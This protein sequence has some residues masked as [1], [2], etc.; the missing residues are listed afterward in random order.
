MSDKRPRHTLYPCTRNC[1]SICPRVI[2]CL[3]ASTRKGRKLNCAWR[4]SG[5]RLVSE[6]VLVG[7]L[8]TVSRKAEYGAIEKPSVMI[9]ATIRRIQMNRNGIRAIFVC[10]LLLGLVGCSPPS[11]SFKFTSDEVVVPN[12]EAPTQIIVTVGNTDLFVGHGLFPNLDE[13]IRQQIT[14]DIQSKVFPRLVSY[15]ADL[16][17][18]VNLRSLEHDRNVWALVPYCILVCLPVLLG[19]PVGYYHAETAILVEI[20]DGSGNPIAQYDVNKKMSGW[21]NLYTVGDYDSP[22]GKKWFP[23]LVVA[24]AMDDLKARIRADRAK[25]VQAADDYRKS[26]D[27]KSTV[28][29]SSVDVFPKVSTL[30]SPKARLR[31]A[32]AP[33]S[34]L[35]DIS[36]TQQG[37]IF[38]T[39]IGQVAEFYDLVSQEEYQRAEEQAFQSTDSGQCTEERCIRAIQEFLQIENIFFLQMIRDAEDTQLSVTL[40]TLDKRIPKSEYCEACGTRELNER[41]EQLLD[42]VINRR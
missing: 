38:N 1:S 24:E 9:F 23:K 42:G 39:F 6:A 41:I 14:K 34:Y 7:S 5:A 28:D 29:S 11:L 31:A 40:F 8:D 30:N 13:D 3:W 20:T 33:I 4:R 27:P 35:G 12:I 16:I 21:D 37:I 17:V 19:A 22:E 32:V 10:T 18:S 2:C 36:R 25:I 26:L 15:G